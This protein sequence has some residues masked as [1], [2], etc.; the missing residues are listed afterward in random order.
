MEY[1]A[2]Y[3]GKYRDIINKKLR[4]YKQRRQ[5]AWRCHFKRLTEPNDIWCYNQ[6]NQ[7]IERQW[8]DYCLWELKYS[9]SLNAKYAVFKIKIEKKINMYINI[10]SKFRGY[11]ILDRDAVLYIVQYL[12]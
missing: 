3:I 12:Y 6:R 10:L 7:S 4:D 5:R 11:N 8:F 9:P 1:Q 2:T